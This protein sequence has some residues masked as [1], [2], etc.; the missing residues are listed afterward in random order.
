MKTLCFLKKS[1][2]FTLI[3][4]GESSVFL[5]FW[6]TLC[7]PGWCQTWSNPLASNLK[8]RNTGC[9]TTVADVS[10]VLNSVLKYVPILIT[11][12]LFLQKCLHTIIY[13]YLFRNWLCRDQEKK[14]DV[15]ERV[16]FN[17][18]EMQNFSLKSVSF[19]KYFP[20]WL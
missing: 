1:I 17:I 5:F 4:V 6:N 10:S 7:S 19:Y 11:I 15:K 12:G 9:A 3:K 8:A 20:R 14:H 13:L 18:C 2:K 16:D